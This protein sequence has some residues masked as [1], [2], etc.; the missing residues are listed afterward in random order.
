MLPVH[1]E[2]DIA[3]TAEAFNAVL[4]MLIK[5]GLLKG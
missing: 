5:E 4:G 2:Q 1:F 3:A